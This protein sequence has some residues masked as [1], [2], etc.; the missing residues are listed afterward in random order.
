LKRQRA[1]VSPVILTTL[2]F[3]AYA[4]AANADDSPFVGRWHWNRSL[5]TLPP[6]EPVPADL[7]T[8]IG[9]A[10]ATHVR[11]SVTVT[12]AQGLPAMR[13]FDIPGNGE[14]YPISGDT[15]AAVRLADGALEAIFNGPDNESDRLSCRLSL[16]GRRMTCTGQVSSGA[17]QPVPYV[18]VYDRN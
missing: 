5:S 11:W 15:A 14:F 13:S 3:I 2:A 9:R 16:Q 18:D 7:I 4:G 17:S 6:G 1:T 10:D 12:N 8:E